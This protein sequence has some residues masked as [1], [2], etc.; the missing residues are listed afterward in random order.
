MQGGNM[1][2]KRLVGGI[3]AVILSVSM[4]MPTFAADIPAEEN[5]SA[6]ITEES[7]DTDGSGTD[8]EETVSEPEENEIPAA[9]ETEETD[10]AEE[11]G[12]TTASEIVPETNI[13]MQMGSVSPESADTA[14]AEPQADI[15]DGVWTTEDF[16]YT[17]MEQTLNGCDYTREFTI[18]GRAIAGFSDYGLKKLETNKDLVLPSTDD[19]GETL[20]GVAD[21]AFKNMGLTSVEFPTGMMVDYD[22]TVTHVVTRRG[23]FIIGSSA[24]Y[25]N[26]LTRLYLPEGVIAV[27]SMAFSSNQLTSVELPH[28]IWW[29]ENQSFAKNQLSTVGFPKTCDFQLQ[30]HA[31]AFAQNNIK[32]VRLP[33]YTE[34]VEKKAFYWNPGMEECP[35][36]AP[37]SEGAKFGGVVYMYTD[38]PDLL[39]MERIHH[40]DRTNESQKSWHQRLIV[41]EDPNAVHTWTLDDF[42]IEGTAITGLSASG[43]AKRAE[44]TSLVLPDRNADG[45]FITEIAGTTN[46]TGLFAAE[47][48]KFE[49]V[50]LPIHLEK[51]GDRAFCNSG[52]K[53]VE[54]PLTLKEIGIAA[55]QRNELASVILPDSVETLGGGAFGT[56]P[57]LTQ[58]VLSR[59]LTEIPAGAF[60]CSTADD[61]M[62]GLTQI[63]I[64]EGVTVIG[65]NAFAGNNFSEIRVPASVKEIG[66]YAFST[67]NYL[68]D[69]VCTVTLEEG[70]EKIGSYAFR[71]KIVETLDLPSTVKALPANAFTR[72]YSDDTQAMVTQVY[73]NEAQISDKENFP[74]SDYHTLVLRDDPTDTVWNA[75]DFTYG[76][77]SGKEL[78][79]AAMTETVQVSGRAVTGFSENGLKKL[80]RNPELVIP[81]MDPEGRQVTA[82]AA[83]AFKYDKDTMPQKITSV[84]FPENVKA[85]YEGSLSEKKERGNFLIMDMAFYGQGLTEVV[86]PEGVL[87]AGRQAFAKNELTHVTLPETIWWIE[88]GAF[89][90]NAI[91]IVDFPKTCDFKL[92]MDMQA[93]AVNQIV[94]VSLPDRTEKVNKWAFMQNTGKEPV[95]EGTAAEKKGGIVYMYGSEALEGESQIAHLENAGNPSNVQK[96]VIAEQDP[97]EQPWN[98]VHF[99]YEGTKIT[100]LSEAGIAKRALDQNLR[101]PDMT[102]DGQYVTEIGA[103]GAYGTFGAQDET[104][105]SV[106]LPSRLQ[107]IGNNAF[108]QNTMT[109]IAFPSTLT[110]IGMAAFRASALTEVILP[111]SVTSVGSGA[112]TTC[113]DLKELT[114]SK[115]MTEISQSAF[116]MTAVKEVTIPDGVTVIGRMAFNG[117]PVESLVLPD[118]LEE[119]GDSAFNSHH[120]TELTVPGSVK[121]IGNSAFSQVS[122][123]APSSL[124]TLVLGEGLEEIGKTAFR[125]CDLTSVEIPSTLKVLAETAFQDGARG[126]V[127]LYTNNPAHLESTGN[128]AAESEGHKVIY[129]NLIGTGWTYEDFTFDGAM[130]TGWSEQ[131]NKTRLEV[132]DLVLPQINPETG[133]AVT[134]IGESAFKIPDDEIEQMKDSVYSPNGMETVQIPDTVTKIGK[135]AFEYNNFTETAFGSALTEIGESA[136]H[137]NKFVKVVL[138]DSVT[139]LGDG[140]F[141]END[142]TDLTLSRGVTVIPQGAFSMNIRM[143]HVDIPDTVTEIGDMAFAGARLTSLTIPSSVEKIGRKAFHLHHLTELTVPGNV[144]EIGESAFEGTFKA[145]TL[146]SLVLEEGIEK[147]GKYAFKEGYLESVQLPSSLKEMGEEPFYGNT[148]T[149]GDH[150]VVCY[151]MNPQHLNFGDSP[152]HRIVYQ[153]Q[154]GTDCFTYEGTIVTGLT[155]K[156]REV[157]Q[158]Y[159]D[160]VIP[161]QTPDGQY[162]TE[163]AAHAFKGCGIRS[164]VLPEK[165]QKIGE[166]A[167]LENLLTSVDLP[168]T[169]TAIAENAFAD[170]GTIVKLI[171]KDKD[172][173]EQMKDTD[174]MD[175]QIVF[176]EEKPE[177]E[178]PGAGTGTDG[179]QAPSGGAGSQTGGGQPGHAV[180][181]GDEQ[182]VLPL[183][184]D[185][186]LA[187][188]A[189]AAAVK[190]RREYR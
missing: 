140:A 173:Y 62:E 24:F 18:R 183:A 31:M 110:T 78:Y 5:V 174:L 111:D 106:T 112:F 33:D 3:L 58:I 54:F 102:P 172:V 44:N 85:P 40:M 142:I 123:T 164:V 48:A 39:N 147:I 38:N 148:G 11:T 36:D 118:T 92:N 137:G 161:A 108:A 98:T 157:L 43:T 46:D 178:T 6:V 96:L 87:L 51:I 69:T 89:S 176:E 138:P 95:T 139:I 74:A 68:K 26:E 94:S 65:N 153:G 113:S 160:M 151:T 2:R 90:Q 163:I 146:K 88:S 126:Q 64:P 84:T 76:E 101:I 56:N 91:S 158:V 187:L 170:N 81:Q 184:V 155:D 23:N 150:V 185:M 80:G 93:F 99:T 169:I 104:F 45:A 19:N 130:L 168:V 25:G 145:I 115:G 82:V 133:E 125:K 71:N 47:D 75:Y 49:T 186:L 177:P 73:V 30:I 189:A 55:F 141:A 107:I 52:L 15:D 86:L 42:T 63:E 124:R 165:L 1:R 181:T 190:R 100:G 135:K 143:E 167:F 21:G 50:S 131:G 4:A 72:E 37:E 122:E 149:N 105:A 159:P 129:S 20:V 34:V 12:S 57:S 97:A 171:L 128:F 60:G 53:R 136:F 16:T 127:V 29:I 103:G 154:W 13:T 114:L 28:T 134:E 17:T 77:V 144:K 35:A 132:K 166:G 175:A 7:T 9:E 32:S 79:D 180:R 22:D 121:T 162:V 188:A 66:N 119:I 120:L 109:E 10:A 27:M 61:W 67:K 59:S 179:G 182:P 152:S 14:A 117:T 70:L 116:A 83:N 8:T 156:G 41:G